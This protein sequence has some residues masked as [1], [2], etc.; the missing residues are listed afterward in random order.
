[1]AAS[2]TKK[3]KQTFMREKSARRNLRRLIIC[4]PIPGE[5]VQSGAMPPGRF[6][7][8]RVQIFLTWIA[9]LGPLL[10]FGLLAEDVASRESFRFDAPLLL[11]LHAHSSPLF[12]SLMLALTWLGGVRLLAFSVLVMGVLAWRKPRVGALF[13]LVSMVGTS[14]LN[15]S[16][17]VAFQRVRP[18]LWLSL[19]PEHDYGFPSGHSMLSC[20]FMLAMLVLVWQSDASSTL[21]RNVTFLGLVFVAGVGLSR[22]YLGVHYPSDVLAGWSLSFAWVA[23]LQGIFARRL[24]RTLFPLAALEA[25]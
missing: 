24:S 2:A 22:L 7:R 12:D 16:M 23:L 5:R 10:V 15:I 25:V 13:L 19:T 8:L 20:T 1:M 4:R 21:K 6:G 14:L 3:G 17:K 11:W 18:N 9:V